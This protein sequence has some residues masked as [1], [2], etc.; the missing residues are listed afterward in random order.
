MKIFF[1]FKT[2]LILAITLLMA[3]VFVSIGFLFVN[4]KKIEI[5][6][7]IYRGVRSFA[8]LTASSVVDDVGLYLNNESFVYFNRSI[9]DLLVQN[10]DVSYIKVINYNGDIIYD[11]SVDSEKKYSGEAR[12]VD[13]ISAGGLSTGG[14]SAG[15]LSGDF[16]VI[17]SLT[18]IKARNPSMFVFPKS[19]KDIGKIYY[20]KKDENNYKYVDDNEYIVA[21]PYDGFTFSYYVQ[22]TGG[23]YTIVYGVTY[24]NLYQMISAMEMRIAEVALF[25]FL[26]GVFL[27]LFMGAKVN[28]PIMKLV[29]GAGEIAKANFAAR[30]DIRTRDEFQYLGESFNKMAEDLGASL[31]AR[32]YKERV[33]KELELARSVQRTI[34]PAVLPEVFG[35]DISA[36]LLPAEEVGGDAYDVITDPTGAL[37]YLGDVTGHGIPASM[38]SA[39]ANSVIYSYSDSSDI[40]SILAHLN[41]VLHKKS[42]KTMFMT[43]CLAKWNSGSGVLR[44]VNA[45]HDPILKFDGASLEVSEGLSGGLAVGMLAE[46]SDKVKVGEIGLALGDVAVLISDGIVECWKSKEENYGMA[47]LKEFIKSY[48]SANPLASA[49]Q[50]KD[51]ILKDVAD[52][53]SGYKQADDITIVVMRRM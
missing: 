26:L 36:G 17:P 13:D 44:Y 18:Q 14:L 20:L 7:D 29:D 37:I 30:V 43:L 9:N 21:E 32:V 22:P 16:S 11:S 2:K 34:I 6:D 53:A 27:A 3:V 19:A 51:A 8:E 4:E 1:S 50:I 46:I 25:G 5:S 42:M 52:F 24:K 45:G 10:S 12:N 35:L 48:C 39:V 49:L 31:E 23:R 15:G 33:G 28:K 40:E 38:L 47:R 41:A